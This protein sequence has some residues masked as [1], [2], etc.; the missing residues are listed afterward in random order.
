MPAIVM[1]KFSFINNLLVKR[2][3]QS[4]TKKDDGNNT[5]HNQFW[6]NF[7]NFYFN[8]LFVYHG[9]PRKTF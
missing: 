5:S 7:T 4:S 8:I 9:Q 6:N 1:F 2:L 3:L